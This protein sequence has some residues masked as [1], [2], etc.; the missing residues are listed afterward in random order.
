MNIQTY[1]DNYM[2]KKNVPIFLT[3]A[4]LSVSAFASAAAQSSIIRDDT[5]GLYWQDDAASQESS[6]DWDDAVA[7]CDKLDLNGMAHWRLPTFDELLYIVDYSRVNPAIYPAFEHTQEDTYWTSTPFAA[8]ISRAWTIDFRTGKSYYS[9]KTTN[10][11]V[12]C[13]KKIQQT[14]KEPK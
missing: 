6:E 3:A 4:F 7:Y 10:H 1:K 5:N 11:A 8:N 14:L 2:M 12:R 9:Y 13:V